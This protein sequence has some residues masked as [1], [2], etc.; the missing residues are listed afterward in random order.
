MPKRIYDRLGRT[1]SSIGLAVVLLIILAAV[2][3]IGTFI[4]QAQEPQVYLQRYG[5]ETYRY[6]RLL[7]IIDLYH[8]WGFRLLTALLGVNLTVC[9]ARRL[10]GLIRRMRGAPPEK[11]PEAIKALK[12]SNELPAPERADII[13]RALAEKKYKVSRTGNAIYGSKGFIGLWGDMITHLSILLVL[14]GALVGSAGFVGTVNVYEGDWTETFY[15]WN[16]EKEERLGFLLF[17]E[18]FTLQ[19]YPADMAVSVRNNVTGSKVGVFK[20]K[21]GSPVFL[22]D[23]PFKVVPEKADFTKREVILD[24]YSEDRLEGVYNTALPEGGPQAPPH[25]PYS[26]SLVSLSAPI[27]KDVA[28]TVAVID[29]DKAQE[30]AIVEINSPLRYGGLTIYHTSYGVDAQGRYY[31]GYQLVRDPGIPLVWAGFTLLM[32]G[33]F[34]S[35]FYRYRQVWVHVGDDRIYI[36]GATDRDWPGFMR[37]YSGIIKYFVQEVE[38]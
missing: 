20:T 11:T 18:K 37:E 6:L 3:V 16:A 14:L 22:P 12:V 1:F 4:P 28:S 8:S 29:G 19:H 33:L 30:R 32:L 21:E 23:T 35:F 5:E 17:V 27:L 9:S 13:E 31:V 26:F 15:N 7:G 24:I 36:G 25:F 34:F 10:T 2:S 38:P